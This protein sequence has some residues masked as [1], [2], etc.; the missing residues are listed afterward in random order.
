MSP[1]PQLS[2]SN[3]GRYRPNEVSVV[4]TRLRLSRLSV[5]ACL[6]GARTH[7]L[8]AIWEWSI[9][10]RR[11]PFLRDDFHPTR[12]RLLMDKKAIGTPLICPLLYGVPCCCVLWAGSCSLLSV[13][14]W[15]LGWRPR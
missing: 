8:K 10:A 2:F 3:S 5:E 14:L 11:C 7:S 12:A 15:L 6:T 13:S 1:K 9:Q 4:F